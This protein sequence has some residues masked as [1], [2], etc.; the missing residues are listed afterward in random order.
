MTAPL[1]AHEAKLI[2]ILLEKAGD[3][4]ANHGCTDFV[5][6]EHVPEMTQKELVALD[7]GIHVWNG[8]PQEHNPEDVSDYQDDWC[9]MSYFAARIREAHGIKK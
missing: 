7:L 2:A 5:M 6:S 9:L 1:S 3:Q 4:F 8:D